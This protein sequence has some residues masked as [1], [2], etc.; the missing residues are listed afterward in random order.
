MS[1]RSNFSRRAAGFALG[2]TLP[3]SALFAQASPSAATQAVRF[4]PMRREVG[5]IAPD[6]DGA[7][8]LSFLATRKTYNA[9]GHLVKIENGTLASWQSEIVAP[10][11]WPGFTIFNQVDT[12][13]D[14]MGR[15]IRD[16]VSG[17]GAVTGVTEYSYDLAGRPKC[18]AVRMNPDVWATP[19]P[20]KCVPGAAH[21]TFGPDRITRNSY[22]VHDELAKVEQAVGTGLEQV[23]S[24][25]TYSPNGKPTSVTDANGNEAQMTWDGFDRQKRWILPSKTVP[26]DAN[27]ADYEEYGYDPNGNRTSLRKRDS[28]TL[29]YQ[30]DALNRL[31]QKIVPASATGAA[32][33]S[34]YYGY[35]LRGLQTYARFGSASGTGVSNVY[36]GFGQL[37]T[38]T[39]N[40]DGTARTLTMQYD[41]NGNRT[42]FVPTASS[43]NYMQ[44]F[45]YDGLDRLTALQEFGASIVTISYDVAGRRSMM[46]TGVPN[47]P[48]SATGW[49]YDSLA[50][51]TSLSH[52]L[53][54]TAADQTLTFPLYNGASQIL[55]RSGSNDSY[56]WAGADVVRSYAVNGLNQ[57]TATAAT[58]ETGASFQ[59]D[60]NGNLVSDGTTSFVYDSEN[61]LVS[62]SGAKTASLAY[63]PLGR[64]WQTGGGTSGTTRFLYDGDRL[65]IEYNASGAVLRSYVH[66]TGADEP[67]VWY[68]GSGGYDRRFLKSDHQ[69]SIVAVAASNGNAIAIN[70]YDP[71]GVPNA[72]NVGRFGYTGQAWIPEL[73][74]YYYKARFYWPKLGRFLQTDPVG[75]KDEM[76]LYAYVGNDPVNGKDPDGTSCRKNGDEYICKIDRVVTIVNG[77][78]VIRN[79]TA[80]D[81]KQYAAVEKS[82]TRAVTAAA[83]NGGKIQNVSFVSNGRTYSFSISNG[84]IAET[85]AART[86]V[87]NP[88]SNVGAMNTPNNRLTNVNR[89]GIDPGAMTPWGNAD[90]TRAKEFIHDGIHG[91]REENR[92]LGDSLYSLGRAPMSADHQNSYNAVADDILGPE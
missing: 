20:D 34:V 39:T 83:A 80:A 64:L 44:G 28:V 26:G 89:S 16:K 24:S 17:G 68:E 79:A 70:A 5:T 22:T 25:Y 67:I 40:M 82:L 55:S 43:G 1:R 31:G 54:G 63:D 3:A 4:D 85:L 49:N 13:H 15:K 46:Q 87:I 75:Y 76:N 62:A 72:G 71:W 9:A 2:L 29:D 65:A 88:F 90:R 30:Y 73:G 35:D 18:T 41:S 56:A 61:R 47:V 91:S 21:T 53:A 58:G 33:Y 78:E 66:G 60:S 74:M 23:Y 6:P 12:E 77:K 38:A 8:P 57:Y 36:D 52:D 69:G 37:A 92:G 51:L 86:I 42:A 48:T 7:G 59:Y 11:N 50:R 14:A 81:R 19:L 10:A 27:P 45:V 32:G 84:R